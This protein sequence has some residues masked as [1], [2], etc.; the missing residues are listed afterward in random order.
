MPLTSMKKIDFKTFKAIDYKTF[1]TS[2]HFRFMEKVDEHYI[3]SNTNKLKKIC[4][5][6]KKRLNCECNLFQ[7]Y[8]NI[9]KNNTIMISRFEKLG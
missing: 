5:L 4:E 2:N 9:H 1:Q 3:I 8:Q 7:E 6:C